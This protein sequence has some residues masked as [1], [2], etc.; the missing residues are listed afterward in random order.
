MTARIFKV[1]IFWEGHKIFQNIHHRFDLYYMGHIYQKIIGK[2]TEPIE[3]V[4]Y[5]GD[6]EKTLWP[7]LNLYVHYLMKIVRGYD[8]VTLYLFFFKVRMFVA[9]LNIFSIFYFVITSEKF[10]GF[11]SDVYSPR[12]LV[13]R[14]HILYRLY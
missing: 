13:V 6:F 11:F 14:L 7:S 3:A 4:I 1:H 5:N 10:M 8:K 9:T 2:I 12:K